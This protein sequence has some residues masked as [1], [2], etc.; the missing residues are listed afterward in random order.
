M[1]VKTEFRAGQERP[2]CVNCNDPF[3]PN[4]IWA[5]FC[6]GRCRS[7]Y[8]RAGG[9]S[10][11]TLLKY[12]D[13]RIKE[14]LPGLVQEQVARHLTKGRLLEELPESLPAA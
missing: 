12:V 3:T 1:P 9:V 8:H 11:H 5:K 6:S 2:R 14:T 13:R 10:R 4:R 7:Q